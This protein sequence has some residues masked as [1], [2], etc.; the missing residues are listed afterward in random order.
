[1]FYFLLLFFKT[2]ICVSAFMVLASKNPVHSVLFLILVFC[3]GAGLLILLGMEFLAMIFLVVYVGAIAVLFLFIVMMLNLKIV[4]FRQSF[5]NH[6]PVSFFIMIFFLVEVYLFLSNYSFVNFS[7]SYFSHSY[8]TWV[9]LLQAKNNMF[10]I[11]SLLYTYYYLAFILSSIVLLVAM[12]GSIVLTFSKRE[13]YGKSQ[14][15]FEQVLRDNK[16]K[17]L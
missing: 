17:L 15:I 11:G 4:E 3:N 5:L 7:L 14:Q 9:D 8:T 10:V 1:M 16:I 2:L 6:Y 12:I 13:D